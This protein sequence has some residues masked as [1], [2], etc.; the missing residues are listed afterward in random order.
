[1]NGM[2]PNEWKSVVRK[3]FSDVEQGG[4]IYEGA[5]R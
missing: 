2:H 4:S 1:M 5:R 3:S